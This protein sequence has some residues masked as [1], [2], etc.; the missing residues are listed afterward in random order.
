MDNIKVKNILIAV[1]NK[2]RIDKLL[3]LIKSDK[4]WATEGTAKYIKL[5]IETVNPVAL[6]FDFDGRL[7]TISRELFARILA[8][9]GQAS[10]MAELEKMGVEPIDLV[11]VDLYKPDSGNFPE[12][13]DI[14]G[15]ALI[16]A[17]IK[18]Y[19]YV[20]LAFDAESIKELVEHLKANQG[21]SLLE[22]RKTQ[23]KKAAKFVAERSKLE[24]ELIQNT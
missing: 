11:V 10:H 8:D 13:M 20:T 5:K 21:R 2:E 16:R 23:A 7:K 17:A 12:S 19:K 15:Q 6:G 24:A 18:N 14:G 4:I 9:R 22:F 3:P 1:S